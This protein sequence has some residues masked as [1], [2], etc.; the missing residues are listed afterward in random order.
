MTEPL[1]LK[2][3]FQEKIWGGSRLKSVY[4]YDIPSD[5]TGE[6]WA[7]SGH[8]HGPATVINGPYQGK[9]L[10]QLWQEE[11]QLFGNAAG[12]VFPLLTKILD[13][14]EDL[15][16]QVHPDDAYAKEHEGELGKTECW[17]VL[18]ADPGAE[19]IYGHHAQTK[20]ELADMIEKKQWQKLFRHVPVKP[21]DFLY[22]PSGT[23][24]AIGKGIMVLETQQS[25]DT[26]YRLYDF[27][28]VDQK[29]GQKRELHLKQSIDC[30]NVPFKEPEIEQKEYQVG[31][32]QVTRFV[33]TKFFAVYRWDLAGGAADFERQEAPYTLV[34]VLDGE[35]Q[36]VVDGQTYQI[37]KGVHFI[38]PY[39]VKK[40]QLKGD[41]S[42]IASE[43]GKDA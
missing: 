29:T 31:D 39:A 20:E 30:T 33:S 21:G 37:E 16:V 11:R 4:G 9:N 22:V 26:T 27:D 19:M 28:R 1:F 7:I 13:A 15:S 25:S 43:P 5:H 18:A 42:I 34:S 10:M 40:W 3:Y 41:L 6:C 2:P 12:D 8:S 36:L 23:I 24:H 32:A 17:Y 35:G 14:K 38:L